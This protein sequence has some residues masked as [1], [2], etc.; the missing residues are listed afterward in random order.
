MV[1]GFF[2][3]LK[4]PLENSRG[5]QHKFEDRT[6]R[7]EE[8]EGITARSHVEYLGCIVSDRVSL[9][10]IHH[11]KQTCRNSALNMLYIGILSL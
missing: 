9:V 4:S 6:I 10:G 5:G 11:R 8:F 7:S 1:C 2:T 3:P